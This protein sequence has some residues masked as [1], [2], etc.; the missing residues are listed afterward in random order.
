MFFNVEE[1][2][3]ASFVFLRNS[4]LKIEDVL[5]FVKEEKI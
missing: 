2:P 4:M 5:Q 3:I 1:E